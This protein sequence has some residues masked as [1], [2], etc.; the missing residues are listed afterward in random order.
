MSRDHDKTNPFKIMIIVNEFPPDVVAGTAISTLY[1][2][3]YLS[4]RTNEVHVAV[5][6]RGKNR[7]IMEKVDSVNIYRFEPTN[8]KGTK[9]IQR[10]FHLY[11]L[12]SSIDPDIIQGQAISCG[13]FAALIGKILKKPSI[14]YIQGYDLYHASTFQKST[15]IKI[16]LKYSKAILAVSEDLK[17]KAMDIFQRPDIV[18]MPHGLENEKDIEVD[19]N[20]IRQESGFLLQNRIILYVGQLKERK[21]LPYLIGAMKIVHEKI[22]NVGL[23]IIGQGSEEK[24]LREK[25]NQNKL[26]EVV[27]FLG[28]RQH[29]AVLAYM[30][31][32]DIFVLPSL[33]EAFGIVLVEAMSQGLPIV[34][35]RI[36]GIPYIVKDGINGFLVPTSNDTLLAEK[37]IFLLEHGNIAREIGEK[38]RKDSLRF[39]WSH[40]VERY[41]EIYSRLQKA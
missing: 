3:R 33:E 2:S 12:A 4:Q 21:G 10:L 6:M 19:L 28:V 35:T 27:H 32:A 38:N 20:N 8:I 29:R 31:L 36:Q 13:M 18:V 17:E 26:S 30:N 37:I 22:K 40:L 39:H 24:S 1:L 23:V 16:A 25:V 7:P 34:A 15:E 11:Q 5:T 9:S 41:I 14:T